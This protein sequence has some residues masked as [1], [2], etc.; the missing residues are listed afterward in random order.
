MVKKASSTYL[1][2]GQGSLSKDIKLKALRQEWLSQDTEQF[3]LDILYGREL[4]LKGLQ[5]KLLC[6]P[7]R[8]KNR[9]VVIRGAAALKEEIK[10][11]IVGYVRKPYAGVILILDIDRQDP[12]DKFAGRIFK[13]AETSRFQEAAL[14]DTFMLGRQIGLGRPDYAL[15]LLYQLLKNGEKPE[16]I[17]GGLRYSCERNAASLLQKRKR[18]KLIL[19]CDVE[20]KT[21]RLKPSFALEKLVIGLSCLR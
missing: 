13:Y 12:K 21:G 10:E 7:V 2:I 15:R 1:F 16:R 5:E 14:P 20:I 3:N 19:G 4:S 18:L 11:F 17:L 8:A 9:I 6:L